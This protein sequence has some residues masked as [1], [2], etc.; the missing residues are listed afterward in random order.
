[1]VRLKRAFD[2]LL[3]HCHTFQLLLV[4][5]VEKV[6]IVVRFHNSS[7]FLC[8]ALAIGQDH[9]SDLF[10]PDLCM[11]VIMREAKKERSKRHI[12][13]NMLRS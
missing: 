10:G 1:M 11:L 7:V 13:S 12:S 8:R 5:I 4:D 6:V 3:L 9:E 2:G